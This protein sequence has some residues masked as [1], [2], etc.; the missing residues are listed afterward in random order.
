MDKNRHQRHQKPH[1]EKWARIRVS[2]RRIGVID[3]HV[4]PDLAFAEQKLRSLVVWCGMVTN[5][6]GCF[7]EL[8][9]HLIS[10]IDLG[11]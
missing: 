4:G 3:P 7:D 2:N 9:R 8:A 10:A 5:C 6:K 1:K 11:M